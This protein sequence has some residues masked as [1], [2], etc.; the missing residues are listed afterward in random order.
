MGIFDRF[1]GAKPPAA[2]PNAPAATP[3]PAPTFALPARATI[4]TYVVVDAVGMLQ[5]ATGEQI[6]F[7]RSACK[8]FEPVVGA[9]VIVEEA[10]SDARGWKAK[11]IT[12][13]RASAEYDGLLAARDSEQ[14]FPSNI[15]EVAQAV[16]TARQLA[17]ITVLMRS[18]IPTGMLALQQW[19]EDLG[20]PSDGISVNV[21][22]DVAFTIGRTSVHS[23]LGRAQF[24]NDEL[25]TRNL[26]DDFEYGES[27]IGLGIGLPG[28]ALTELVM[29]AG[30]CWASEGI[31]RNL[32]R[33]V[34]SLAAQATGVVLHRAGDVVVPIGEFVDMLGD[35]DDNSCVPFGAWLDV[36]ITE[37]NDAN[38]Y[39]TFGMDAFGLPDVYVP[40]NVNDRWSRSRC[41]EAILYAC[42]RMVR[43]RRE[44]AAG[45]NLA[46][47]VRVKVGAW[48]VALD[49]NDATLTYAV[50]DNEGL[51]K[52]MV[53]AGSDVAQAWRLRG[54]DLAVNA[55]QALFDRG[56]DDIVPSRKIRDVATKNPAVIPHSV[57]IRMRHDNRGYLVVTNGFGRIAIKSGAP[58]GGGTNLEVAAWVPADRFPL[59]VLVGQVASNA[60]NSTTG[61]WQPGDTLA[62]AYE[63][64]GIAG[65]V[66]ADG[67]E[68]D[69]GGGPNVR[70][71]LLVPLA[72]DEYD[73][74]RGGGATAWLA[75]HV[76]D[77]RCW[78]PFVARLTS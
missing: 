69:M 6:R 44:L 67:G 23:C 62:A 68:V 13:D 75:S 78:A 31:L 76:V 4:A 20:F 11:T 39:S 27:F 24:P 49:A 32:S 50:T 57:E 51:I 18:P 56:L 17:T 48:P 74:V 60:H 66:L 73:N 33:L 38:V 25:D 71:L 52:L 5:L 72:K 15:M 10:I 37:R 35:L 61:G 28:S 55:Y 70:I 34:C 41:H 43:E 53:A 40:V 64:I 1:R 46:V 12:L 9:A 63:E 77:E 22:R 47:P 19:S 58:D 36:G 8:G 30:D 26:P 65:F 29:A 16:A 21:D 54:A 7:G 14:G 2:A 42:Y 3:N 59:L 45:E